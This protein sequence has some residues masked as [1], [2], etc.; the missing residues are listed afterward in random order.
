MRLADLKAKR[1]IIKRSHSNH[2]RLLG[3]TVFRLHQNNIEP[4]NDKHITRIIRVL[5]EI[6]VEIDVVEQEL[7]RRR[8]IGRRKRRKSAGGR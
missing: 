7:K 5:D 4:M 6:K 3:K 2:L 8:E 1:A